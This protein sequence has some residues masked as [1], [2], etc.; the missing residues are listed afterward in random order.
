[1]AQLPCSGFLEEHFKNGGVN[2]KGYDIL[3]RTI[4]MIGAIGWEIRVIVESEIATGTGLAVME[5]HIDR[6]LHVCEAFNEN[7][8]KALVKAEWAANTLP[9]LEDEDVTGD[10][11]DDL[12]TTWRYKLR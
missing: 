1:M 5:G 12:L 6:I 11:L 4:G 9:D 10:K 3:N 8:T 2:Q 7:M